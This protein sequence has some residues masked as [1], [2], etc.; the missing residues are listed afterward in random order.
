MEMLPS[1]KAAE[2][3]LATEKFSLS[4][5][6]TAVLANVVP[7]SGLGR[8]E[9]SAITWPPDVTVMAGCLLVAMPLTAKANGL[10]FWDGSF[11]VKLMNATR[12]PV[13]VGLNWMVKDVAPPT[14]TELLGCFVTVKLRGFGPVMKIVPS[15]KGAEP[16]LLIA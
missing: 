1:V 6:P 12:C 15:V 2:P 10:T 4:E 16:L 5:L 14:G 11:W 13:A 7:F 8:G 3:L 9:P